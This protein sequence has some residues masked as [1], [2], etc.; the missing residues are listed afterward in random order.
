M[1]DL[2]KKEHFDPCLNDTFK[3]QDEGMEGLELELIE[4]TD[5][6]NQDAERFSLVFKGPLDK[7]F[8]QRIYALNNEKMGDISLFL[9]PIAFGKRDAMYYE[10]IFNRL[11]E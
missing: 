9:V 7:P 3:M 10:S 11:K 2:L 4:V 1:T 8:D 5:K 6:S